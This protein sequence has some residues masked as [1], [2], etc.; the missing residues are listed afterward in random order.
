MALLAVAL[1]L[2]L[3]KPPEATRLATSSSFGLPRSA[4]S[5][6]PRKQQRVRVLSSRG[7]TLPAHAFPRG[8]KAIATPLRAGDPPRLF[9]PPPPSQVGVR[10]EKDARPH[11]LRC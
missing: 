4:T 1:G 9:Q 2:C 3:S 5:Y 11:F 7:S 8:P 6:L 10:A